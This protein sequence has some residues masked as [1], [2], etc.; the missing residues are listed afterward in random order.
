MRKQISR[1]IAFLGIAL[2]V[3][4]VPA[5][6]ERRSD[7]EMKVEVP[8]AFTVGDK[9]LPAGEYTIKRVSDTSSV[10]WIQSK[11][12]RKVES[13]LSVARTTDRT[14]IS[15]TKAVFNSYN[16]NYFLSEVW[17]GNGTGS[18]IHQGHAERELAGS[19]QVN[20]EVAVVGGN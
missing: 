11:D 3:T 20:A 13:T 1:F 15:R 19:G 2:I 17:L 7:M 12:G 18:V 4:V 9:Q 16:G 8:F 6:A 10:Y 5:N 14:G